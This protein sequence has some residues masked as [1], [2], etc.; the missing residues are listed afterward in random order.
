MNMIETT[1]TQSEANREK[2]FVALTSV[3][4]AIFLTAIKIIVGILTGSL[5]ILSEAAHSGLDLV[6]ALV[7]YFAVRIS[8]RPADARYTYGYG[9]VENISALFETVLLLATCVWIIYEAIQRLFY[10]S[11]EVEASIWAF[12]IM[13]IS[14]G[15]DVGRSRALARA[16]KKYDSQALEAD[17]LHF[18]TDIWSSSVVIAGLLLVALSERLNLPW[19]AKADA[20]AAM[21]VA[22]I[23]VFVSIQLGR[24]TITAL[25]DAVPAGLT[26]EVRGVVRVPGVQEIKQ[27]RLRRSGPETFADITLTAEPDTTFEQAQAIAAQVESAVKQIMPGADV[28]VYMQPG[29]AEAGKGLQATVRRI[30]SQ[31]GVHIHSIRVYENGSS[32]RILELHMEVS[33]LMD[34]EEAHEKASRLEA[35]LRSASLQLE[36]ITIHIEPF[37]AQTTHR[38]SS[39]ADE[40]MILRALDDLQKETGFDCQAHDIRVQRTD[41]GLAVSVHCLFDKDLSIVEVHSQTEQIERALRARLPQVERVVIHTEPNPETAIQ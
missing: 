31:A 32:D 4:A 26:D 21:G 12:A 16:A 3:L 35:A 10:K 38:E 8:G 5:G 33:E 27:V 29:T 37:G 34:L 2:K 39:M 30:A 23:V 18:S 24:K 22:G 36:D 7:T 13:A 1:L 41:S 19:L 20:V 25:L 17:A 15:V 9:K 28:L 40:L 6:A 14:I 11:V